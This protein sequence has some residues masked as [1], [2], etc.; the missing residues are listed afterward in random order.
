VHVAVEDTGIGIPSHLHQTIF[1]TFSQA[2]G[3]TTRR[4]GGTGLG[5]SISARL[6]AMMD[7]CI[8]L[9]SEPG[10]GSTF[11]VEFRLSVA[12]AGAA[13][14]PRPRLP[15]M[16]VL[17]V[18][19]NVVNRRILVE[20]LRR[21]HMKPVA[22]ESG[23]M[24]LEAMRQAALAGQPFTLVLLDANRPE[25]DGFAVAEQIG[26]RPDLADATIMMPTSTGESGDSARCRQLGIA[27]YLVKPVR[28]MDLLEA[29]G[30]VL[31]T[32]EA[33]DAETSQE[34]APVVQPLRRRARVL[35]A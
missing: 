3:S 15:A 2:D 6:A 11:H 19:D 13:S 20:Q 35:L 12:A 7:G 17:V 31:N 29:I 23:A 26:H 14:Q 32:A 22:V 27:A 21:W 4:F 24:A 33:A 5:L 30:R 8:W 16:P 10:V 9:E 18:D 1:D 28:P 34:A 25:I